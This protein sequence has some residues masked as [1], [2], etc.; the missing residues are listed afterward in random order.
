[1]ISIKNEVR[2]SHVEKWKWIRLVSMRIW[3][4]SVALLSGSGIWPC[5][6]L[7]CRLQSWLGSHMLWLWCRMAAVALIWL[8]LWELSYATSVA[9]KKKEKKKVKWGWNQK[10]KGQIPNTQYHLLC[11]L[12]TW[13]C[14]RQKNMS[15]SLKSYNIW[16]KDVQM[17]FWHLGFLQPQF[18]N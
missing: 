9:I 4:W 3:V 14:P 15:Y 5:C 7:W 10:L 6:E 12:H 2:S 8:L 13:L 17:A 1:M 16:Q 11:N 18:N